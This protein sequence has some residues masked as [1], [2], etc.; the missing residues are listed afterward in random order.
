MSTPTNINRRGLYGVRIL[1]LTLGPIS[2]SGSRRRSLAFTTAEHCRLS[3]V[4]TTAEAANKIGHPIC[5]KKVP[6]LSAVLQPDSEGSSFIEHGMPA[7]RFPHCLHIVP[8]RLPDLKA[9]TRIYIN[10]AGQ[11]FTCINALSLV[12]SLSLYN[13]VYTRRRHR[14]LRRSPPLIAIMHGRGCS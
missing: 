11:G 13:R 12:L 7:R 5:S 9:Q 10:M 14:I 1:R 3:A 8:A 2:K 4:S 6:Y